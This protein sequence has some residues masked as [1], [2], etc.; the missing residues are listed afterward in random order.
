MIPARLR[1]ALL[2]TLALASATA[3]NAVSTI[4]NSASAASVEATGIVDSITFGDKTSESG[5]DL[6]ANNSQTI[7]GALGE[8]SRKLLPFQQPGVDG[9][10]LTFT[11]QIDP[12][13]RN[14]VSVKLWGKTTA[15]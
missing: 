11:M 1:K 9:G 15:T 3:F 10:S 6:N 2:L 5:H 8:S 4:A 12:L 7:A 14:Y 13:R